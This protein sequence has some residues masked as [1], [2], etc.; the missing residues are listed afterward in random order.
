MARTTVKTTGPKLYSAEDVAAAVVRLL[1]GGTDS[2]APAASKKTR[3]PK[4]EDLE[5]EEFEDED[6]ED[7]DEEVVLDREEVEGYKIG[8]LRELAGELGLK[9]QK[10]KSGILAELEAKGY[11]G[12]EEDEEEEDED[13]DDED[14]EDDD[15]EDEEGYSREELE[16]M[17]LP[18]LKKILKENGIRVP[19]GADQDTLIDLILDE[20][21]DEEDEE[22]EEAEESEEDEGDEAVLS[23]DDLKKMSL[24]DLKELTQELEI[25]VRVPKTANTDAKKK[26]VY[27]EAI[28][29][30]ADEDDEE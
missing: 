4:D 7:G 11:Y 19:R 20:D 26:K 13:V 8:Q 3:A 2:V 29:A 14:V 28:L 5:E 15:E 1:E 9:E 24:P 18:D 30:T 21:E 6:E 16:E 23:E 27:V 17:D 25:K 12:D 10:L 22:D